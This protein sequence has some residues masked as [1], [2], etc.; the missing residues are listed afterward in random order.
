MLGRGRG[1]YSGVSDA[2]PMLLAQ[3]QLP[4]GTDDSRTFGSPGMAK[5][6]QARVHFLS[7][8]FRV[9]LGETCLGLPR[10]AVLS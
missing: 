8:C 6:E 2:Q 1:R 10:G 9:S 7:L 4:G 5:A 3:Q